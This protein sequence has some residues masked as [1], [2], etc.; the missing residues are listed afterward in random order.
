MKI[1]HRFTLV[2]P[3]DT[4]DSN[5]YMVV[6]FDGSEVLETRHPFLAD[7]LA[8]LMNRNWGTEPIVLEEEAVA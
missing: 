8:T 7:D 6:D 4:S 5:P 1:A 2:P 3:F